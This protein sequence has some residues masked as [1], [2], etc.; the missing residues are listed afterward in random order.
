MKSESQWNPPNSV[1]S[2]LELQLQ[3]QGWNWNWRSILF[4]NL[5]SE[6]ELE[7]VELFQTLLAKNGVKGKTLFLPSILGKGDEVVGD[8]VAGNE[9]DSWRSVR[10]T[11]ASLAAS[12]WLVQTDLTRGSKRI[13]GRGQLYA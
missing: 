7:L 1:E 9:V 4:R 5:P 12:T 11:Q 13:L 6:L 3:F 8:E 10:T 2:E